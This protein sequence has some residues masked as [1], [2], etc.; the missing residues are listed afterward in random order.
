MR[1]FCIG[2]IHGR[3]DL[4]CFALDEIE[5]RCGDTP[6]RII[7]LGDFIDRGPQSKDVLETLMKGPTREGDEWVCIKGNHE[8]MLLET[9]KNNLNP[10][11]WLDNGGKAT[12]KS[13]E[14]EIPGDVMDWM[15]GL[16]VTHETEH[17]FFVH[18]G[19]RPGVNLPDQDPDEMMWIRDLFLKHSEFFEKHIVHGHTPHPHDKSRFQKLDIRTNLDSGSFFSS[20]QMIAEFDLT[21]PG[22][23]ID[24]FYVEC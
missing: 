5:R 2:D 3:Y 19:V 18:A 12:A 22:K 16:P 10:A 24:V 13:F 23:P 17:H 9:H 21:K 7:F 20:K 14:G 8:A 15:D 11:W 4:L 1:T 6:A